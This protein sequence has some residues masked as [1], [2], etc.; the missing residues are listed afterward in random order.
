MLAL[1]ATTEGGVLFGIFLSQVALPGF[2]EAVK[3][4]TDDAYRHIKQWLADL[5][6]RKGPEH[7]DVSCVEKGSTPVSTT[8]FLRR[9]S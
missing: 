7:Y 6:H 8:T 9:R 3:L 5:R 2:G 4:F 1:T